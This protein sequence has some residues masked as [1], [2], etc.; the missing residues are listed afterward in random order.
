LTQFGVLYYSAD[1]GRP[2]FERQKG[3]EW[4]VRPRGNLGYVK[5]TVCSS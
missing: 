4:S 3:V 5:Q 2:S 1:V